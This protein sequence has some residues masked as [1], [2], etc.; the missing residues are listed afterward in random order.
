MNS[1]EKRLR[2]LVL[3]T[4]PPWPLDHGNRLRLHHLLQRL[5]GR[6]E[7]TLAT[8]HVPEQG[9]RLVDRVS[10][11]VIGESGPGASGRAPTWSAGLARRY[12]GHNARID[13]W[14]RLRA[15]PRRFDVALCSGPVLGQHL[16]AFRVPVVWDLVDDLVL[17]S[18]R[19]LPRRPWPQRL[20]RLYAAA[21]QA[22]FERDAARH[23]AATVVASSIDASYARRWIGD[24]PIEVISN[25][26]DLE[27]FKP[28]GDPPPS[29]RVVFVGSLDFPPN[30][31]GITHFARAVWPQL[32]AEDTQRT[33][34]IVGR[35]PPDAVCEAAQAPGVELYADVPDVRPFLRDAQVVVS[36]TRSGG[37]VK[38]KVL[39]ACAMCRPVVATPRALG[40]LSAVVGRDVLA[41]SGAK[42]WREQ[43]ARLLRDPRLAGRIARRG[44]RWVSRAH[45]W[46]T[47]ADELYALL[48]RV[49]RRDG[50][51]EPVNTAT[52]D[53]KSG[54]AN[55][56]SAEMPRRIAPR[57]VKASVEPVPAGAE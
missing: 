1:G 54:A 7:V 23:A 43:V 22:V 11:S 41:A 14:L 31:D 50:T 32:R 17:Y 42:Q 27:Y 44:R 3:A 33:L 13:E 28:D 55:A 21:V 37:G 46:E 10:L 8:P 34:Q 4:Q 38:N 53:R 48:C 20:S 15:T 29:K 26:V 6:M 2:L 25:G 57:A 18:V 35:R 19:D 9:T 45:R 56:Q 51:S 47:M 16:A 24:R 52:H 12:F 39:E 5:A 40:G 49:A 30:A 36:P